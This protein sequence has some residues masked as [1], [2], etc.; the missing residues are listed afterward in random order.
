MA[1]IPQTGFI[2]NS[3]DLEND[4]LNYTPYISSFLYPP[5]AYDSYD[6]NISSLDPTVDISSQ[7]AFIA[8]STIQKVLK[9]ESNAH[10]SS[11]AELDSLINNLVTMDMNFIMFSLSSTTSP[12]IFVPTLPN[13]LNDALKD[14]ATDSDWANFVLTNSTN[15]LSAVL[16]PD[17]LSSILIPQASDLNDITFISQTTSINVDTNVPILTA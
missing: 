12:T 2:L 17:L 10:E 16:Y 11:I 14:L 15:N 8:S 9:I 6:V 7:L 3:Y 5:S 4:V 1:S 13:Y